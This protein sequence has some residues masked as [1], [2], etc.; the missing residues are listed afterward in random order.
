MSYETIIDGRLVRVTPV[1]FTVCRHCGAE[2]MPEVR[3]RVG[4]SAANTHSV[5]FGGGFV[6]ITMVGVQDHA[7]Q[8]SCGTIAQI[9]R[10]RWVDWVQLAPHNQPN[11]L[12]C[13]PGRLQRKKE[14]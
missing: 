11:G 12:G 4:A 1:P 13:L 3:R 9:I 5:I 7:M 8:C 14:S 10:E 2:P 6:T